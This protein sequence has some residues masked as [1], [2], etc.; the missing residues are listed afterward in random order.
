MI[1]GEARDMESRAGRD[2]REGEWRRNA[3]NIVTL[4]RIQAGQG[5]ARDDALSRIVT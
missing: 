2:R 4:R 1:E 3:G 5:L